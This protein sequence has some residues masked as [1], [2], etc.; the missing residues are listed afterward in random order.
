MFVLTFVLSCAH[1]MYLSNFCKLLIVTLDM[2]VTVAL[3]WWWHTIQERNNQL[4]KSMAQRFKQTLLLKF[5][6]PFQIELER[7]ILLG[8]KVLVALWRCVIERQKME[9]LYTIDTERILTQCIDL[10]KKL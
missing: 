3:P 5:H 6:Y 8:G 10:E 9:E 1:V 4:T 7:I 2:H